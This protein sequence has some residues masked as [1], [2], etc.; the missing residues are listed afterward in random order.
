MSRVADRL[1]RAGQ[2]RVR[3]MSESGSLVDELCA[4]PFT[5]ITRAPTS[6][7]PDARPDGSSDAAPDPA[8]FV[9]PTAPRDRDYA[10]DEVV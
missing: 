9:V 10:A 5:D 8:S 2:H 6:L 1:S 3:A 7:R 4:Q